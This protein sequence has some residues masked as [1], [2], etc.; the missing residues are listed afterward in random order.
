M[1]NL[2]ERSQPRKVI[3]RR[4]ATATRRKKALSAMLLP[5]GGRL[6]LCCWRFCSIGCVS[7][8]TSSGSMNVT[9]HDD[10]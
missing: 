7:A 10:S 6:W 8:D 9:V 2:C 5:V 3:R 4:A 1:L